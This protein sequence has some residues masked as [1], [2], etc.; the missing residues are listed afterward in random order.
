M[1]FFDFFKNLFGGSKK[2]SIDAEKLVVDI[3][4]TVITING[5]AVDVPCHLQSL[6]NIFG[7]PRKFVGKSGNVNFTWDDLGMY[8]YTKGNNVVHCIAVKANLSDEQNLSFEPKTLFK[9]TLTIC[10]MP[11]EEVMHEG[12]DLEVARQRDI[13]GLSLFSEYVDF[14]K[15]DKD[16]CKGAYSG[17]EVSIPMSLNDIKKLVED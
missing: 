13:G 9:G 17:V 16:G 3:T 4:E 15:G 11:W 14:E 10:G 6:S 1:G 8:C 7:K 2:P 12:D 5:K